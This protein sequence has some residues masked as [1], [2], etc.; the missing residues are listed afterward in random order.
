MLNLEENLK[1]KDYFLIENVDTNNDTDYKE[2][3]DINEIILNDS[4]NN[5]AGIDKYSSKYGIFDVSDTTTVPDTT[6]K[7]LDIPKPTFN[8]MLL[9][10]VRE[11]NK[12]TQTTVTPKLRESD[13]IDI[14]LISIS[15]KWNIT[16]ICVDKNGELCKKD[17][18]SPPVDF[19]QTIN[20][21]VG[22][23]LIFKGKLE[24]K[25][26]FSIKNVEGEDVIT[27]TDIDKM[28]IRTFEPTVEGTYTYYDKTNITETPQ[29]GRIEVK[30]KE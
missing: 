26:R 19:Y 5:L 29:V 16:S 17:I 12:I 24:E 18:L 27:P 8:Y 14:T 3:G 10:L 20:I 25:Q 28:F 2:K 9:K 1:N 13:T 22:D 7:P 15:G 30:L 23:K 11:I 21:N 4:F 6:K